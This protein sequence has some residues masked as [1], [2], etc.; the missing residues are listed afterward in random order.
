MA[1]DRGERSLAR[2]VAQVAVQRHAVCTVAGAREFS[3]LVATGAH[4]A[5]NATRIKELEREADSITH[6]CMEA[7]HRAFSVPVDRR[8]AYRLISRMDDVLDVLEAVSDRIVLFELG[9]MEPEVE[10]L[11]GKV[12]AACQQLQHAL[13]DLPSP[14]RREEVL[15]RCVAIKR[16]AKEADAILRAALARLLKSSLGRDPVAV[17]KWKEI[18]EMTEM[19]TVRCEDAAKVI[20]GLI[21]AHS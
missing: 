9:L 10:G 17:I 14:N 6:E 8:A 11:A 20:E 15:A 13:F 5:A 2:D 21:L 19:A 18:F 4:I 16:I 12:V 7:L 3:A 1:H